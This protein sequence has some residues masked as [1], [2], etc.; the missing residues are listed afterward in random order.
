MASNLGGG[1]NGHLV[2]TMTVDEYLAQISHTF[3]PPHYPN[4][5]PPNMWT[6]QE[7]VLVIKNF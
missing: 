6:A 1:R 4:D 7:Q 2:L 3:L 5:Y